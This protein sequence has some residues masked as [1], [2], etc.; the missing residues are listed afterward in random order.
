MFRRSFRSQDHRQARVEKTVK[1]KKHT[2]G[3]GAR[4]GAGS[5]H[6][7][8]Y[9]N[10]NGHTHSHT[11]STS[12][13]YSKK[14][15]R[16]PAPSS[17]VVTVT[18]GRQGRLFA[19][20][21]DV[22]FQSP[23]FAAVCRKQ[24]AEPGTKRVSL[25]DE[26][27]AV[28]SAVLEYLYKK[29]YYPRLLLNKATGSY[30]LEDAALPTAE[31]LSSPPPGSSPRPSHSSNSRSSSNSSSRSSV[32]ATLLLH[33]YEQPLLR[34]TVIYC[35]AEQYGL[36][37]LKTLAIRKQ[38]LQ[39]GI[40]VG[41]ILR[42]AQYAYANTPDSDSRLRAHYLALIIRCRRTF[43][44]SG[45]LQAEMEAGGSKLYFDLFVALCNHVDDV[46]ELGNGQ[47]AGMF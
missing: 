19:A 9:G 41:T 3:F 40:D 37:G 13:A 10:G 24:A 26:D 42:S 45:T 31:A 8:V 5:G 16:H 46:M 12:A 32:E 33:G 17:P 14:T 28:F 35:A 43:K 23:F 29:D 4:D 22:L 47:C 21:E 6:P 18:V 7:Q 20:H 30:E 2:L 1:L 15:I 39:S 11:H 34:D 27:P 38:G 36:D 44:R 25:P